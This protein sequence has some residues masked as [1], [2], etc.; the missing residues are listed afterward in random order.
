MGGCRLPARAPVVPRGAASVTRVRTGA[1]PMVTV[2]GVD[3]PVSR[4]LMPAV[5]EALAGA[6]RAV[7][8]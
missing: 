5:R 4:R 3:V 7:T 8:T 6:E 2:A 1:Q